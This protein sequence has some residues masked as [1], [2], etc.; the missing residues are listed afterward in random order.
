MMRA[1]VLS[2]G[3]LGSLPAWA[4]DVSICYNYS[5]AS[6]A[7]VDFSPQ[8]IGQLRRLFKTATTPAA[9]RSAIAQAI[10]LFEHYAG[11]Q[12]PTWRDR[13]G[14]INDNEADGRMDCID[15]STNT[16]TYLKLLERLGLLRFH[17]VLD[18]V[19]RAPLIVNVHWAA[20]IMD[21]TTRQEYAVDSWFHDNGQPAVIY[22]LQDWLS[23]ASPNV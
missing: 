20:H 16:T 1:V 8:Q 2:L 23:G 4:V 3:L 19:E 22:P 15:H 10:G 7:K 21:R 12:T 14:N 6:Q 17:R 18:P 11:E 13:G 9:E 5:C